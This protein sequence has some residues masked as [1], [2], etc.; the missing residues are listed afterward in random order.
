[1]T[2][3]EIIKYTIVGVIVISAIVL[4]VSLITS[5]KKRADESY[6]RELD[7]KDETIMVIR[8]Q[9]DIYRQ[10]K[11]ERDRQIEQHFKNDSILLV[12]SKQLNIKYEKIPVYIN[13]LDRDELRAAGERAV[14]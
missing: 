3:A 8:E 1:M 11:E 2:K 6:K 7:A 5:Y 14:Q 10:L 9:R 13:S 12:R 4:F